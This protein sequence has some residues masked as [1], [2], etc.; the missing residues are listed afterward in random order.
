MPSSTGRSPDAVNIPQTAAF[1]KRRVQTRVSVR[2]SRQGPFS[3]TERPVWQR[4]RWP[5]GEQGGVCRWL[6]RHAYHHRQACACRCHTAARIFSQTLARRVCQD[7]RAAF[8]CGRRPPGVAASSPQDLGMDRLAEAFPYGCATPIRH[9]QSSVALRF[10]AATHMP[11]YFHTHKQG[12]LCPCRPILTSLELRAQIPDGRFGRARLG[13]CHLV[14]YPGED[15]LV[16]DK[17]DIHA[18]GGLIEGWARVSPRE[19]RFH[20]ACL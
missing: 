5:S 19:G 4:S 1:L 14:A 11:R 18:M 20:L 8:P 2:I 17:V 7:F 9:P 3:T 13:D 6:R 15:R 12:I 10:E 16:V